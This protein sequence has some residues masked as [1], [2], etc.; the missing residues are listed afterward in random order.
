AYMRLAAAGDKCKGALHLTDALRAIDGETDVEEGADAAAPAA[1][2]TPAWRLWRNGDWPDM[3]KI[4]H[5]LVHAKKRNPPPLPFDSAC[6]DLGGAE[7]VIRSSGRRGLRD[8]KM[9]CDVM[10]VLEKKMVDD[11]KKMVGDAQNLT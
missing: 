11:A 4:R 2:K 1:A 9:I 3:E 6:D 7:M 10:D 5:A 8:L